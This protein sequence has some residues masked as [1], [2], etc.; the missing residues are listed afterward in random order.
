MLEV[1]TTCLEFRKSIYISKYSSFHIK[2]LCLSWVLVV[3]T[4]NPNYLG[5]WDL[6]DYGFRPAWQIVCET[7]ISKLTRIKWTGG[8][9]QALQCLLWKHKILSSNSILSKKRKKWERTYPYLF[10]YFCIFL[11]FMLGGG[12]LY[13]IFKSSYKIS[14]IS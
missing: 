12:T 1:V 9:A 13:S 14:N 8:M 4:C 3:H 7:P 6:E 10:I 5:S 11:I 2:R